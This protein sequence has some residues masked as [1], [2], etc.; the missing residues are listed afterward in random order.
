L[1]P[2]LLQAWLPEITHAIIYKFKKS[3]A[4]M[5]RFLHYGT[6]GGIAEKVKSPGCF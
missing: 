3:G 4:A 2:A 6:P 1:R 5:C